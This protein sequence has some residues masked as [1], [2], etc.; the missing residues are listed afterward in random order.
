MKAETLVY[1]G[2]TISKEA[3][4]FLKLILVVDQKQRIGW[5]QLIRHPILKEKQSESKI[6]RFLYDDMSLVIPLNADD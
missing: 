2:I 6:S 5:R 3:Y 4:D 1:K